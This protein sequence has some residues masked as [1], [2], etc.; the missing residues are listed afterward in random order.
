MGIMEIYLD[1]GGLLTDEQSKMLKPVVDAALAYV[2]GINA[3]EVSISF[4]G[5]DEMRV[6]NRDYRC[7]DSATDVLSFPANDVIIMGPSRP[8]GDIVICMD[9]ARLQ[10]EEYGHS[11]ERELA[12]LVVHGML[13]LLGFDHETPD[14]EAKMRIAQSSILEHLNIER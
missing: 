11:L 8:L 13:H 5:T 12:F 3:S 14:E 4:M 6:L 10:A 7:K 1:D 2:P 9:I